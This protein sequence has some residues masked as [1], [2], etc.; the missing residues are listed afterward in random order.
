PRAIGCEDG[1][2]TSAGTL[3]IVYK[4]PCGT[5]IGHNRVKAYAR[6]HTITGDPLSS[7]HEWRQGEDQMSQRTPDGTRQIVDTT[8]AQV[9]HGSPKGNQQ[10]YE[11]TGHLPFIR[12]HRWHRHWGE[13]DD[14]THDL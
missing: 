9:L 12:C 7:E 14:D 8:N 11:K 2:G 4:S 10:G 5:N 6:S 1:N 13:F 3:R